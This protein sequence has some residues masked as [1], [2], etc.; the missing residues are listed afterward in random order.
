MSLP[1][2][3][4]AR[5]KVSDSPEDQAIVLAGRKT[6]V[7][8]LAWLDPSHVALIGEEV[9]EDS[10]ERLVALY[11]ALPAAVR[12]SMTERTRRMVCLF[13]SFY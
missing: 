4:R 7:M 11:Y 3:R 6:A 2:R 9:D 5:I 1:R 10:D 8:E 12:D 13:T